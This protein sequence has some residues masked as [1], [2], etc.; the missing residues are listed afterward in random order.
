LKL[1]GKPRRFI[2]NFG[3]LSLADVILSNAVPRK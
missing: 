1:T 3:L 2:D